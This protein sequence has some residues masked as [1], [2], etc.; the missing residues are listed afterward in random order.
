[1]PKAP[2]DPGATRPA[3][4][5]AYDWIDSYAPRTVDAEAFEPVAELVRD[6]LRRTRPYM[7]ESSLRHAASAVARCA[8]WAVEHGHQ[9][10]ASVVFDEQVVER[11]LARAITPSSPSAATYRSWFRKY[12]PVIAP[13]AEWG[14]GPPPLPRR[15]PTEP[16]ETWEVGRLRAQVPTQP[17]PA[18]RRAFRALLALGLGVGLDGRWAHLVTADDVLDDTRGLVVRVG[19]PYARLVPVAD[20]WVVEVRACAEAGDD[21]RTLAGSPLPVPR[22]L[23][24]HRLSERLVLSGRPA[25]LDLRRLRATWL[26]DRLLADCPLPELCRAAGIENEASLRDLWRHVPLHPAD[27]AHQLVRR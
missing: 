22:G 25:T 13:A 7:A 12:G 21:G 15:K 26:L 24:A 9:A 2:A 19:R 23:R 6:A 17:T 8:A 20:A 3:H 10:D 1:M 5:G 16:Y 18:R 11:W 4:D 27:L 14:E